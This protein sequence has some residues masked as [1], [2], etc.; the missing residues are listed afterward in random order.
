MFHNQIYYWVGEKGFF[1][2]FD[3]NKLL[4]ENFLQCPKYRI[5]VIHSSKA[6]FKRINHRNAIT[7][8]EYLFLNSIEKSV[9]EDAANLLYSG[10]L[11]L[12]CVKISMNQFCE[13]GRLKVNR[14]RALSGIVLWLVFGRFIT[15]F[16][17]AL[18]ELSFEKIF[19]SISHNSREILTLSF[20][21]GH[22]LY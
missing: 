9:P 13:H 17:R 16:S 15:S 14:V 5:R 12:V 11:N 6:L 4:L 8:S 2:H 21:V 18:P 3:E 10:I 20:F 1:Y 7:I 19:N 22:P